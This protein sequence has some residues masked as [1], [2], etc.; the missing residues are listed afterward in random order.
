M[1]TRKW[2]KEKK[3]VNPEDLL[4]IIGIIKT[5]KKVRWSEEIDEIIYG[6]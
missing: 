3:Q 2:L 5:R 4:Q 1:V 6:E